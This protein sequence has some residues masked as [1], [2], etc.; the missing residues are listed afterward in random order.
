MYAALQVALVV[1][2]VNASVKPTSVSSAALGIVDAFVFFGLSALEHIR[3]LRSS[4]LFNTYL[5]VTLLFNIA[6]SRTLWLR[7]QHHVVAQVF[8]A[9]LAVKVAIL[10]LESQGKNRWIRSQQS[11]EET[12]GVFSLSSFYWLND[13]IIRGY[14]RILSMNDLYVLDNRLSAEAHEAAFWHNW[15]D[16]SGRRYRLTQSLW[17][18]LKWPFLTPV[19]PRIAS[20]AFAFCQP[21]L[22]N[23]IVS[24]VQKGHDER[25]REFGYGL[26]GAT[27]L[28]YTGLAASNGLYWYLYKRSLSML[29][30]CLVT[31]VY[32]TTV[33]LP[34]YRRDNA[35]AITLMNSDVNF[36]QTGFEDIHECWAS[37]VEVAIACWL[38]QRQL[39]SAFVAPLIVV[40][41]C[42][43]ASFGLGK[44]TGKRMGVVMKASQSRV[45]HTANA[46][47]NMT[48]LKM[49]G[50]VEPMRRLLQK[51]RE[52]EVH[53]Q[54][55]FRFLTTFAS[56]VAFTPLLIS[57]VVAFAATNEKLTLTRVFT[58]LAY[59][60]L[61]CNPL[62]KLFQ[63]IPHIVAALACISRVE[64]FLSSHS[65]A[66]DSELMG[67][68]GQVG[69]S[70]RLVNPPLRSF[71][72]SEPF[73]IKDGMVGWE[74]GKP[75]LRIANLEI[76]RS[77]LTMIVGPVACGKSTLCKALL[78]ETP[79]AQGF[80][81]IAPEH[82]RISFCDQNAF[83]ISGTIRE[84]IIGFEPADK[85]WY[86]QVLQ[87]TALVE[88]L[89]S[90]PDGENSMVGTDGIKLSGGQRQ[91]VALARALFSRPEVAIFDDVLSGLDSKTEAHVINHTLG[92]QG[93]LRRINATII[94]CTS[95]TRYLS[96][97]DH[98]VALERGTIHKQGTFRD[99]MTDD[100]YIQS[101]NV[102]ENASG[103]SPTVIAV[104]ASQPRK[105]PDDNGDN[106]RRLGGFEVYK[107]YFS[108]FNRYT[109][110]LYI[111]AGLAFA[112]LFN[113]NTV[114][115][116][117][118][119]SSVQNGENRYSFY[120]GIYILIQC[121]CVL[122]VFGFFGLGGIVMTPSAGLH[123]HLRAL[124]AL[125]QAP[126]SYYTSVDI[127]TITN[128][129]SQDMMLIDEDLSRALSN[130]IA[131]GLA[132]LGQAAVIGASSPLVM[133]SY[134]VLVGLL[135]I[136]QR[137]YLRTSRQLR[138]LE[139][140]AKAPL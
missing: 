125:I 127:G 48:Y 41:V 39:G 58:S 107:F 121:V 124:A 47:S 132:V 111:L 139:L 15:I 70:G 60:N 88:D 22:I 76:P 85:A 109:S 115:L 65:S 31:A 98:I 113:F 72:P 11:P 106:A 40:V 24:Y 7:S 37:L 68:N 136:V 9:G 79:D 59:I 26:I 12:S 81:C 123:V 69:H 5:F 33:R 46:I 135:Y 19:L 55:R 4:I 91:R 50:L 140:E 117:F 92:G 99:F 16:S 2:T 27:A 71:R 120:L 126:L 43:A 138:F 74:S 108:H 114:W 52:D 29:R 83:L 97:A 130:T 67:E 35:A 101:L 84:N 73:R 63:T 87:A 133:V 100:G 103:E 17:K 44:F 119:S 56:A 53:A 102:G 66:S 38:L 94:L 86:D 36:I 110:L 89:T 75:T 54:R 82:T 95:S 1:L 3:S 23:T 28:I 10:H 51:Y 131:T 129:F 21:F 30:V 42:A 13:L 137:I 122:L 20:G 78:G 8:T 104:R 116:E 96:A 62:T 61:L 64:Q 6:Q 34:E 57:P 118:W 80:P 14:R 90:F 105:E 18:T 128:H 32:R 77:K 49:A 93:L 134:P 45:G 25:R 112:F